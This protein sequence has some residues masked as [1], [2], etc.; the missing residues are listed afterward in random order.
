MFAF[1]YLQD[2]ILYGNFPKDKMP[3]PKVGQSSDGCYAA[4]VYDVPIMIHD[5]HI[6]TNLPDLR[7]KQKFYRNTTL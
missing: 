7:Q 2:L 4:A 1:L 5:I 3:S 6:H